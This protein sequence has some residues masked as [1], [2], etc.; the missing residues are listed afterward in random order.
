MVY[1]MFTVMTYIHPQC[2]GASASVNEKEQ[3]QHGRGQAAVD[4]GSHTMCAAS[5]T[6]LR[7][8]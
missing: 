8:P 3:S 7:S 5:E 2:I 4:G 6:S 1:V